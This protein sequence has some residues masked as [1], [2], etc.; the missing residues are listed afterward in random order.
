MGSA[1]R[2]GHAVSTAGFWYVNEVGYLAAH[3]YTVMIRQDLAGGDYG[4]VDLVLG[5]EGE[6]VDY[7][8]NPDYWTLLVM[9]QLLSP[10]VLGAAVSGGGFNATG[11]QAW[12]WCNYAGATGP[13][14]VVVAVSNF[15]NASVTLDIALTAGGAVTAA[16]VYVLQAPGDDLTSQT[17]LLNGEPIVM[18]PGYHPPPLVGAPV[19]VGQ[20][21]VWP[22]LSYGF[23]NLV[24]GGGVCAG[25]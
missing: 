16:E 7:A 8:P 17:M 2:C 24:G 21:I 23:V 6:V 12:A 15:N 5:S 4:L 3:G 1:D 20:P 22:A 18:Q 19:P 9:K 11:V 14:G 25:A 10:W 13:T